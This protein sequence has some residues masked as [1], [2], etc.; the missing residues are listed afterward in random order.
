MEEKIIDFLEKRNLKV[1]T[2][3]KARGH[4][5]FFCNDK[6]AI[7]KN[8]P[9]EKRLTVLLHEFT[10]KIHS[11]IEP[12]KFR[13]GGSI[14]KIFQTEEVELFEKELMKVT[15]FVD[16]NARCFN[17]ENMKNEYMDKV[18]FYE[19]AIKKEFP[20]FVKTKKFKEYDKYQKQT[21]C[22]SKYFLKYD[23]IKIL[24]PWLFKSEFYSI[25][26]INEDFPDL[27]QNFKNYFLLLSN[28]RKQKKIQG[29]IAKLKRY[30]KR[31]TELFSRF[32]EG[33][34][35]DE[36]KVKVIAPNVYR[37]FKIL[38]KQGYY[39]D[40]PQLIEMVQNAYNQCIM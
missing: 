23:H 12:L 37:Q 5:G 28:Y 27:P 10:H 25:E 39:N 30:Y 13:T 6:I 34:A 32:T 29:K 3:T 20:D 33:I 18:N 17:L 38:S 19:S 22:N 1:S 40:L 4:L 16:E 31:P 15:E 7:S 14:E 21:K 26:R 24:S 9:K 36:N 2:K 35:K 8:L 11:E